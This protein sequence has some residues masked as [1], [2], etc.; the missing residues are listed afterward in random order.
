MEQPEKQ[1]PRCGNSIPYN[2]KFCLFCGFTQPTNSTPLNNPPRPTGT[3]QVPPTAPPSP[4]TYPK[5]ESDGSSGN[6]KG[7]L[8]VG[9]IV[10]VIV[11]LLGSGVYVGT[12]TRWGKNIVKAITKPNHTVTVLDDEDEDAEASET[13]TASAS[14]A[15][16]D[17]RDASQSSEITE[18]PQAPQPA[19]GETPKRRTPPTNH[20]YLLKGDISGYPYQVTLTYQDA[21][22]NYVSGTY[23]NLNAGTK[24]HVEGTMDGGQLTLYGSVENTSFTFNLYG[25]S[26][27]IRPSSGTFYSGTVESYSPK[28]STTQS[29]RLTLQ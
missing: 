2:D 5:R 7:L 15:T 18:T 8:W 19:R 6:H 26:G 25:D 3:Q 29:T 27:E 9:I 4:H 12:Q 21:N 24:M 13:T 20:N 10:G 14:E 16:S 1:C 22:S 23:K 28:G 11:L 17:R